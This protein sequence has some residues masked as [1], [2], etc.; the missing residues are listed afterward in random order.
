MCVASEVCVKCVLHCATDALIELF[1]FSI[2]MYLNC[3]QS[4]RHKQSHKS[5]AMQQLQAVAQHSMN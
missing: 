2:R 4:E 1:V 5:K 3:L